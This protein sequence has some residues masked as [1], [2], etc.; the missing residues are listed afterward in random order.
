MRRNVETR[1]HM[2]KG[3]GDLRSSLAVIPSCFP[4]WELKNRES[5][6]QG[7][8]FLKSLLSLAKGQDEGQSRPW[9][10][11]ASPFICK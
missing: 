9:G 11:W 2:S 3:P 1:G 6:S 5:E 10:M 7:L 8:H 4:D